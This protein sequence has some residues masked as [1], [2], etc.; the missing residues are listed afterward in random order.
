[1][2]DNACVM[3]VCNRKIQLSLGV[4]GGFHEEVT[5]RLRLR[6]GLLSLKGGLFGG[7]V[8]GWGWKEHCRQMRCGQRS[9]DRELRGAI[10]K[11][12]NKTE[13]TASTK[14]GSHVITLGF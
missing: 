2:K 9:G 11:K 7:E 5:L 12:K 4:Q 13:K 3:R 1:M 8:V 14:N 10:K 6:K